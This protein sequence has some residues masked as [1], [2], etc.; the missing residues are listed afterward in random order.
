MR[1]ATCL[2]AIV[3][4]TAVVTSAQAPSKD[5]AKSQACSLLTK[6][7]A[8]AA[9]GEPVKG[10]DST[11]MADGKSACEYSGS[12]IHRVHLNVMPMNDQTAGFY[13]AGCAKKTK[14]GL[15]GLGDVTCWYDEKHEELQVLK[16]LTFFSI[17]L[18]KSGDP[19]E[20]IKGVARKVYEK[21]K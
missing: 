14:D 15:T 1:I 17:Q 2:A 4:M 20:A 6:E 16:G 9:L 13:K 8:A 5:P 12:G 19:T 11:A 18:S 3:L 21:L 7:D 10:P